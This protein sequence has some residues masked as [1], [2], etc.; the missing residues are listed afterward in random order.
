MKKKG[1]GK[2]RALRAAGALKSSARRAA[3]S[4]APHPL[5]STPCLCSQSGV[6]LIEVLIAVTLLSLLMLGMLFAMRIGLTTFAKTDSKLMINRRVAGAQRILDEEL[7]GLMPV[8]L[9]SCG[10]VVLG[11]PSGLALFQGQAQA[12]R[13]VSSFSLQQAWRGQPQVLELFVIGGDDGRGVRLVVNETAYSPLA[14]GAECLGMEADPTNGTPVARFAPPQVS[15]HSF[16]LAD[17]L[18]Y[19]RFSY[20]AKIRPAILTAP[21][22]LPAAPGGGWPLAIRVEMAP[23]EPNPSQLEPITVTA[24]IYVHRSPEVAYVDY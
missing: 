20:L 21:T 3:H 18:A 16:V 1:V 14:A 12:M 9:A 4:P 19:C 24:P 22:W 8:T 17:R 6:T 11:S 2:G 15:N 10:K 7:E 13:L 5:P 23:L